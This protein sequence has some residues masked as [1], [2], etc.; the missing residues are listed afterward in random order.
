MTNWLIRVI[1]G[2]LIGAGFILPGVS[3]AA[4][5]IIFGL[6][7][8]IISFLANIHKDF[9]KNIL[10]FLP[11]GIGGC[12]GMILFAHPLKY[13][14][15]NHEPYLIWAFIGCVIGILPK[16]WKDARRDGGARKHIVILVLTAIF[17]FIILFVIKNYL[18][19]EI[20]YSFWTWLFAGFVISL[21]AL[22]PGLSSS[23]LMIYL[24]LLDGML[25]GL[26]SLDMMVLLPIII[27][28]AICL[29]PLSKLIDHSFKKAYT[30]TYHFVIGIVIASTLMIVPVN[31]NYLSSGV[32]ICVFAVI[33]GIGLGWMMRVLEE[34][35]RGS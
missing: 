12:V 18:R 33:A 29:F 23:N 21:T 13:L 25:D 32:V 9:I 28:V 14:L 35:Y 24:G 3:G 7:Q 17:G 1:K 27:G 19:T 8:R 10:Y 16:L 4:L 34:K 2:S 31:F 5:A 6:Y 20:V 26:K 15:T 22:I 11:V 30:G